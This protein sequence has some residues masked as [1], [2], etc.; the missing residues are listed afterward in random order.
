[1]VALGLGNELLK[2][3]N[4]SQYRS[5]SGKYSGNTLCFLQRIIIILELSTKRA[6]IT[7]YLC[8]YAHLLHNLRYCRYVDAQ[9]WLSARSKTLA[10][11]TKQNGIGA[12]KLRGG[13]TRYDINGNTAV[14]KKRRAWSQVVKKGSDIARHDCR[15]LCCDGGIISVLLDHFLSDAS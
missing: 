14:S 7:M 1:M 15:S 11:D 6:I 2:Y 8:N 12:R 10:C 3:K 5:T 9:K 4:D 13:T